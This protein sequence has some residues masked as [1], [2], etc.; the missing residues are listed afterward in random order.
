VPKS[1]HHQRNNPVRIGGFSTRGKCFVHFVMALATCLATVLERHRRLAVDAMIPDPIFTSTHAI[2][3]DAPPEQVWQW[4]VQMGAGRA[5][6]YRGMRLTTA[7]RQVRRAYRPSSRRW[8]PE[9]SCRPAPRMPSLSP[10]R[11][12]PRDLVLTVPDGHGG[13]AVA[14]EHALVP[15]EG[16]RTRRIVRGRASSHWLDLARAR[17]PSGHRRIFIRRAKRV[18]W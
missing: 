10:R 4:I 17:P 8:S 5:G 16:D 18:A 9:T 12:P 3:I 14:W 2:T 1:R 13:H 6:W 7:A 11:S 15:L